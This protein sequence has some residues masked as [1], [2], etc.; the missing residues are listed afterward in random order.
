MG[1]F[2]I[3]DWIIVAGFLAVIIWAIRLLLRTAAPTADEVANTFKFRTVIFI[4][5]AF[6]IPFWLITLPLFLYLAY[7]SYVAGTPQ[8]K[9]T[10]QAVAKV[11]TQLRNVAS[12]IE[13]LHK[14]VAS[15]A[16][17]ETEFQAEKARLLN[18]N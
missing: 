2:S 18:T 1:K 12:E 13:A 4:I 15:G 5:L 7:K 8:P 3:L 14:L 16:L 9:I 11:P 17:S 6:V 10:E